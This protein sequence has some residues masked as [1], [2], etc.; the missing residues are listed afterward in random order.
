[1]DI[2][3]LVLKLLK[4]KKNWVREI[5]AADEKSPILYLKAY[6]GLEEYNEL[7]SLAQNGLC[8]ET[9]KPGHSLFTITPKGREAFA[10]PQ[11]YFAQ[12][13]SF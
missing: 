12:K 8:A 1:M 10:S 5:L 13:P 6:R 9:K 2:E 7:H 11:D 4:E 3:A